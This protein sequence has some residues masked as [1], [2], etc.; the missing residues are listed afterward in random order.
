MLCKEEGHRS[1]TCQTMS[2]IFNR[3]TAQIVT[4]KGE[5]PASWE[6][7]VAAPTL[8]LPLGRHSPN[9]ENIEQLLVVLPSE[10][11]EQRD[12]PVLPM[13]GVVQQID[14]DE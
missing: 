4:Q 12:S 8:S 14:P 3:A 5:P 2:A 7:A 13:L 6:K 11:R 1:K 9:W 10:V